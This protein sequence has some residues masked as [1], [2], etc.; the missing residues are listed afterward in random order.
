MSKAVKSL[1]EQTLLINEIFYSVQG[2]STYAGLPC[3]FVR[4]RG[5]HLRCAYC[6]TEYA[7]H[8]GEKQSLAQII[9][10][11]DAVVA[12]YDPD[13]GTEALVQYIPTEL[14]GPSQAFGP[15]TCDLVE[16]TGGEPLLQRNVHP[17]MTALCDAGK[18]VLVETSGACD[19]SVCD[20]RVIRI[21]DLK[22]PGSGEAHRN[23]W[24]NI[25]HLNQRD[26][27][28][29]VLTSRGDYDWMVKQ[30]EEHRLHERVNAVLVSAVH[31]VEPGKEIAGC[32][33][34]SITQLAEWLLQDRLPVRL[35][36][37]LHKLIWDPTARGV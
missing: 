12:G 18:T 15:P 1:D 17:L 20:P 29:F 21:M 5:C 30:L 28:K 2:E 22:T 36:T 4:L 33:G 27:V 34:L 16:I 14:A 3:V 26:E 24:N 37:Q 13:D 9:D 32:L 10:S 7:F 6:D 31:K 8:E 19:I 23:D 25:E 35:Q 11:V